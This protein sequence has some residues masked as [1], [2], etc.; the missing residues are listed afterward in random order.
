M[1]KLLGIVVL[2]LLSSI[3]VYSASITEE[4]SKLNDLYKSG[5]L[6]EEE[7]SKA[8]SILLNETGDKIIIDADSIK[9]L[10]NESIAQGEEVL[11]SN[12]DNSEDNKNASG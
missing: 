5:A 11:K 10:I 8:K 1:K 3:K 12:N 6:T 4:L 7:F 2:C 9:A